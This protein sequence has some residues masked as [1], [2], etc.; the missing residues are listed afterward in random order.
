MNLAQ[1]LDE[2]A[3]FKA[4][5]EAAATEE[6]DDIDENG[7]EDHMEESRQSVERASR[8]RSRHIG[9]GNEV[10]NTREKVETHDDDDDEIMEE[11]LEENDA[12]DSDEGNVDKSLL[13]FES[14]FTRQWIIF[15][16]TKFLTC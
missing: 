3:Q 11:E 10:K 6:E 14:C 8:G 4:A 1:R 7:Y 12:E 2:L 16:V 15:H 9:R 5:E 13:S